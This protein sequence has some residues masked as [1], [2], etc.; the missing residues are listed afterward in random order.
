M[1][2]NSNG[3]SPK[4]RTVTRRVWQGVLAMWSTRC[5][6]CVEQ[7]KLQADRDL[8]IRAV[9]WAQAMERRHGKC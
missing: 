7:A 2:R 4:V 3:P 1:P 5:P 9:N 8:M 6:A